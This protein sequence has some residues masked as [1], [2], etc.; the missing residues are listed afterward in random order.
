[1]PARG[2]DYCPN[3]C[4]GRYNTAVPKNMVKAKNIAEAFPRAASNFL[5]VSLATVVLAR[6]FTEAHGQSPPENAAVQ[7]ARLFNDRLSA[8]TALPERL[9]APGDSLTAEESAADPDIGEQW[10][11]K[12]NV[13]ANPFTARA[14]LSLFFTNNVALAR[15]GTRSDGFAVADVGLNYSRRIAQAWSFEIDLQQSFFRYDRLTEFDFES[16]NAGVALSYEARQFGDIVF[17]L[18]YG[19]NRLTSSA[20]EDQLYLGNTVSLAAAKVVPVTSAGTVEFTA[21][22]GYTFADAKDLERAEFR[23]GIGYR[24]RM[25]RNLTA[26]AVVRIELCDYADE[27]RTDLLQTIAIGARYEV[28]EWMFLT[29]SIAA[30]RNFSTQP[31]FSYGVINAG[32]TLAAH[33][34]F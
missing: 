23:F 5:L 12:A 13:P 19:L 1:M 17:T 15:R 14:S 24:L 21:A 33:F 29:A 31:V 27:V 18:L 2:N 7:Q 10:M 26:T 3:R 16:L 4:W 22:V 28:S 30:A 6:P 34:K 20:V 11:L 9:G 8:V 32:I 25:A